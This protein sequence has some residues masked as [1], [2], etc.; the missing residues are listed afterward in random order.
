MIINFT[1]LNSI[2]TLI[3]GFIVTLVVNNYYYGGMIML[4]SLL[5]GIQVSITHLFP[6]DSKQLLYTSIPAY[7]VLFTLIMTSFYII[8]KSKTIKTPQTI[9]T[10]VQLFISVLGILFL[11]VM[12]GKFNLLNEP[13]INYVPTLFFLGFIISVSIIKDNQ[14]ILRYTYS[15]LMYDIKDETTEEY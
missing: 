14:S 9:F 11:R 13:Y 1:K 6:P 12:K 4:Y 2:I 5:I 8:Y 7:T 15:Q 10:I 3:L